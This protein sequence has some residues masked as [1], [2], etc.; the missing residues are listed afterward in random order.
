MV[1]SAE[2][3]DF[4][5]YVESGV[6]DFTNSKKLKDAVADAKENLL[7]DAAN[8]AKQYPAVGKLSGSNTDATA[9]LVSY[10]GSHFIL[11]AAHNLMQS[12]SAVSIHHADTP[13]D[14]KQEGQ[15]EMR[16]YI[17]NPCRRR[18]CGK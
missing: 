2:S 18:T 4:R 11:T 17:P 7:Q 3:E 14:T 12:C 1:K 8:L 15:L 13:Q 16:D 5:K 9:T 6:I 10:K